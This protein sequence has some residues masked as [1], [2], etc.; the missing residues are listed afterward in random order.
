MKRAKDMDKK[1]LAINIEGLKH[2]SNGLLVGLSRPADAA[3]DASTTIAD[4]RDTSTI[5]S[6]K[7]DLFHV[8]RSQL[9]F[10]GVTEAVTET[11]IPSTSYSQAS[12]KSYTEV[13]KRMHVGTLFSLEFYL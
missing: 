12:F 2:G 1:E 6:Q 9:G 5:H 3:V 8:Q 11:G 10:T 13:V 7:D 4:M